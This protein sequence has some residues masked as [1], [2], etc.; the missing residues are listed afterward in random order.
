M[1][2]NFL[3]CVCEEQVQLIADTM[4]K[5]RVCIYRTIISHHLFLPSMPL[6]LI[7]SKLT[8]TQENV[9][10]HYL[11]FFKGVYWWHQHGW[12]SSL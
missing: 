1:A 12:S 9:K 6:K 5:H 8:L 7:A 11:N 3:V 4:H 10:L 2:S